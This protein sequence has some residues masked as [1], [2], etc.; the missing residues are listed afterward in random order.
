MEKN[1]LQILNDSLSDLEINNFNSGIIQDNK[2]VF[3]VGEKSYRVRMPIQSE[4]AIVDNK[5]NIAQLEFIKQEGCITR[6]QL[7]HL[8]KEKN[9]FDVEQ[10]EE[11]REE[12]TKELK[13]YWFMLATKSSENK[14][15]IEDL[16]VKINDVQNKLKSIAIDIA[17]QLAPSLESR[18][19]KF[20]VEYMCFLCTDVLNGKEWVRA[21]E[22]FDDYTKE[23][24]ELTNR[25]IGNMTWLLLNRKV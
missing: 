18:L 14:Q 11:Q 22:L 24:S 21:W 16:K 5:R 10:V 4:Q 8:L 20:T 23:D 25:C 19:E 1:E 17:T 6:K 13:Q 2:L 15:G 7:I 9:V 3:L 12:L